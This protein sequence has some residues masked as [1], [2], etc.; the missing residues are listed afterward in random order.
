M[1]SQRR[2][3]LPEPT[4]LHTGSL[5]G[6]HPYHYDTQYFSMLGYN[7]PIDTCNAA[8]EFSVTNI[9]LHILPVL[10]SERYNNN[11]ACLSSL[12]RRYINRGVFS[13]S[14][15]AVIDKRKRQ[16]QYHQTRSCVRAV[17]YALIEGILTVRDRRQRIE[18]AS[19]V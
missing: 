18:N 13:V 14:T 15:T 2:K 6:C 12:L 9:S 8:H 16:I 4:T 11:L 5:Q 3:E 17:S 1:R 10:A 7:T 19:S